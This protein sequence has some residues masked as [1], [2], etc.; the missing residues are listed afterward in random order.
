MNFVRRSPNQDSGDRI[1]NN[2]LREKDKEG[3]SI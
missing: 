3:G 1:S 2:K